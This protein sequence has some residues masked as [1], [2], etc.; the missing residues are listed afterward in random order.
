MYST[1]QGLYYLSF[2]FLV[3]TQQMWFPTEAHC[4][5]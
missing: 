4:E 1:N 5:G 3:S 2:K